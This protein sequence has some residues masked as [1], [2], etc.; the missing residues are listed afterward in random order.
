LID[1][2]GIREFSL[3]HLSSDKVIDG[4]I[5]FHP[6]LGY[7]KFRDCKHDKDIGCALLAAVEEGKVLPT[8][9][10][11]YRQIILSQESDRT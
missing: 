9:L 4:F 11:N 10:H 5:D 2:P 1:S 6:Y 7:C 3:T 8:R